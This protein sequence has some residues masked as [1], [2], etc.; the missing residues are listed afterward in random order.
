MDHCSHRV[1]IHYISGQFSS[2]IRIV[3]LADPSIHRV[4]IHGVS[5]W[6]N[7]VM[8]T[9][10]NI[11]L[12]WHL[13][14]LTVATILVFEAVG[15]TAKMTAL[16]LHA[17]ANSDGE[18]CILITFI[19]NLL[20]GGTSFRCSSSSYSCSSWPSSHLVF[21]GL[22]TGMVVGLAA[23]GDCLGWK[24]FRIVVQ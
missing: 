19:S 21:T 13:D 1:D 15:S 17:E 5:S 22:A 8:K 7:S 10:F 23:P 11:V 20:N 9:I 3:H 14:N 6:H 2:I 24:G 16:V 4:N 18:E 12:G